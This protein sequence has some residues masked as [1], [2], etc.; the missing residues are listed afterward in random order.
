MEKRKTR[1]IRDT[2]IILAWYASKSPVAIQYPPA[3]TVADHELEEHDMFIHTHGPNKHQIWQWVSSRW[4][5][6]VEGAPAT[7]LGAG[8]H[9]ILVITEHGQPSLVLP[10]T[11]QRLYKRVKND[12]TRSTGTK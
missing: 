9:R 2:E 5:T 4:E 7:F 12:K 11:V 10:E 3:L 8:P 6:M 1:K